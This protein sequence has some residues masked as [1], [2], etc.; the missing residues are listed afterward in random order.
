MTA[1]EGITVVQ[2]LALVARD[3]G[4]VSKDRQA[5]ATGEASYA[6][7]GIDDVMNAVHGPMAEHGVVPTYVEEDVT[8]AEVTR[9]QRGTVWR[10][11]M[12]R[13]RWTFTGPAGDSIEIVN[14]GEALDNQDKGLGKARSYAFKDALSRLL[15][16]PTDE[17]QGDTE[18]NQ[19]PEAT[20]T[21]PD[22]VRAA[23]L[24][25]CG[26]NRDL[27]NRAW[28]EVVVPTRGH[29]A[30]APEVIAAVEAWINTPA[31]EASDLD[32]PGVTDGSQLPVGDPQQRPAGGPHGVGR[33]GPP[34]DPHL[35][36]VQ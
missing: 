22:P 34:A 3:V 4:A 15:T 29:G 12:V 25:L 21:Q 30:G 20:A 35:E 10:H 28:R 26:G 16:L 19:P 6:F 32:G 36:V 17:P 2:A 27:A 18:A 8:W 33:S 9:G 7:R 11:Y 31:D 5:K 24:D 13:I 14:H 23:V 1:T